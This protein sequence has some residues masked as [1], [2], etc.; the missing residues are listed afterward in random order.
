MRKYA[1]CEDLEQVKKSVDGIDDRL[2][3]IEDN[4]LDSIWAAMNFLEKRVSDLRWWIL[5]SVSL[6][7]VVLAIL[8]VK[9]V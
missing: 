7:G 6:L 3:D 8:E 2:E 4:H 5:G 9:A 1:T